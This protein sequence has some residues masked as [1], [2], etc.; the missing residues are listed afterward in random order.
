MQIHGPCTACE[1]IGLD[2]QGKLGHLPCAEGRDLSN[3]TIFSREGPRKRQKKKM[4]CW[5]ENRHENLV[6]LPTFLSLHQILRFEKLSQKHFQLKCSLLNAQ[7][8]GTKKQGK[9]NERRR[10]GVKV[11]IKIETWKFC[12]LCLL[13]FQKLIYFASRSGGR[14]LYD[15]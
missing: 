14:K 11:K 9:I 12:F 1:V 15:L 13:E 3:C 5:P 10:R 7:P 6:P 2:G 8:K 4:Q